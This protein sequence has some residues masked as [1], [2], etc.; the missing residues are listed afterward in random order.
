MSGAAHI[1][2]T[3]LLAIAVIVALIC[4]LGLVLMKDFYERLHYMA[5][6]ST[7]SSVCVL[8]AVVVQEGW[9]QATLK[10]I[11]IVLVLFFM[12]ATLTHATAR[13]A[14]VRQLGHWTADPEENI[15][16]AKPGGG[17]QRKK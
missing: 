10:T 4:C 1:A 12:N 14:R 7:I 13:A 11:V 8:A 17:S 9:G 5:T 16:V 6:V 2:V 3:V 15:P